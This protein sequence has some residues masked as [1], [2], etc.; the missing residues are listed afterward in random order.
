MRSLLPW[1]TWL[2]EPDCKLGLTV[3]FLVVLYFLFVLFFCIPWPLIYEIPVKPQSKLSF[4]GLVRKG[5]H[6]GFVCHDKPT[7]LLIFWAD[8]HSAASRFQISH[9]HNLPSQTTTGTYSKPQLQVACVYYS[10]SLNGFLDSTRFVRERS[11]TFARQVVSIDGLKP[12]S[13]TVSASELT[14]LPVNTAHRNVAFL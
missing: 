1:I 12:P 10:D 6:A 9:K 7:Q 13:P 14:K 5:K 3:L 4:E 8:W 2:G 11:P